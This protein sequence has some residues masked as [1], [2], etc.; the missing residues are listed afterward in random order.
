MTIFRR[1]VWTLFWLIVAIGV[2]VMSFILTGMWQATLSAQESHHQSR[3]QLISQ[4]VTNVLRTQEL[5]LM[6]PQRSWCDRI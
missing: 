6:W 3:V 2:L 1:N 4:S 5:I